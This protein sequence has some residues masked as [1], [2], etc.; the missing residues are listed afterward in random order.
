MSHRDV[1]TIDIEDVVEVGKRVLS[2]GNSPTKEN[3][4]WCEQIV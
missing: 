1:G 2:N 3:G 4:A